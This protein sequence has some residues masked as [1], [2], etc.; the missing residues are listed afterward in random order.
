MDTAKPLCAGVMEYFDK[1]N[2]DA[3]AAHGKMS[4]A[5]DINEDMTHAFLPS[6]KQ[7]G[8]QF[9]LPWSPVTH[10]ESDWIHDRDSSE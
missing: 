2:G 9:P 4:E 7:H 10:L 8:K 3:R 5:N 6:E 1:Y